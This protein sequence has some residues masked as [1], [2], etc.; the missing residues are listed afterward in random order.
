MRRAWVAAAAIPAACV[1]LRSPLGAD[2]GNLG[3]HVNAPRCDEPA[4]PLEALARGHFATFVHDQPLMGPAS[5]VLRAPFAA[6]A[7]L[8]HANL[9]WHYRA[10]LFACLLLSALLALELA[11]RSR[12]RGHPWLHSALVAVLAF[13]TP[14]S[15]SAVHAGHPEE[16]VAAAAVVGAG[17]LV[18]D[19]RWTLAGV[20]LGLG[21]A[22]KAW[23]ILAVPLL[24][25]AVARP[26]RR[27]FAMAA[28]L[29][30]LAL[31][32]PLVAGD[33]GRFRA[34][35]QSAGSLGTRFGEAAPPDAWFA[36]ERKGEFVWPTA[37]SNGQ[38]VYA[39]AAG[40]RVSP[41]VARLARAL[42]LALAVGLALGWARFG[43]RDRPET[44][45]L[46]LAAILLLRCALDPGDHLYYHAPAV[47]ALVAYDA[48]RPRARVPWL[49]AG[50]VVALWA[51]AKLGDQV[52]T[53]AAAGAVYLAVAVPMV[54]LIVGLALNTCRRSRSTPLTPQ[55]LTSRRHATAS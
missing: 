23:V 30:A 13:A 37:I 44:L 16:L 14:L 15:L 22:T 43:G 48:L 9:T 54:A 50:S 5:F 28:V 21:V 11:R 4:W 8:F 19:G 38:F 42:V 24:L 7:W 40:D 47:L 10:G 51:A 29:V 2:Y 45:M 3:C 17:L 35:V 18:L 53:D 55:S 46:V 12:E 1:A 33:P 20:V 41:D 52:S 34:V 31:Y 6:L 27:R 36:A 39:E 32:A 26:G 49:S 25:L